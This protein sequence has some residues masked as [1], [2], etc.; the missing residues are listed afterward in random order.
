MQE[1]TVENYRE[2]VSGLYQY[3]GT[4]PDDQVLLLPTMEYLQSDPVAIETLKVVGKELGAK[5]SVSIIEAGGTRG[6]PNKNIIQAINASTTFIGMGDKTPN[7]ITGQCLAALQARWDY[8]A[9][10]VDLRGGKGIF[11]TECSRYPVEIVLAIARCVY[12]QL[13]EGNEL[14]ITD[15]HGTNVRVPYQASEVFFGGSIDSDHFEAGQRCDWPLGQLMLHPDD[16]MTG[17]AMIDCIKSIPKFLEPPVRYTFENCHTTIE[18]REETRRIIELLSKPE[19]TLL[20]GKLFLGLNP[21]GSI[22]EGINRSNFGSLVQAAGVTCLYIGDKAGYVAS[23]FTN[24]GWLLKPTIHVNGKVLSRN[25]RLAAFDSPD[26]RN[27]AAK[28]GNPDDLLNAV[29]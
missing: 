12:S 7:P 3:L 24:S 4:K 13:V 22:A 29:A 2:G 10:Q 23:E 17:V 27:I 15:E 1:A 26:V 20:A 11:A 16:G 21:R 18:N 14:V 5:V 19:N 28:Y 6:Q 25:G 8:G 9:K